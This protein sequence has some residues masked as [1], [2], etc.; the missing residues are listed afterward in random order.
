MALL[1]QAAHQ[2][3]ADVWKVEAFS[4]PPAFWSVLVQIVSL[5]VL[6]S[7]VLQPPTVLH[8]L[9]HPTNASKSRNYKPYFPSVFSS[10]MRGEGP[11][12][13]TWLRAENTA[14]GCVF[15]LPSEP[16]NLG[17]SEVRTGGK[18]QCHIGS[19]RA[20]AFHWKG[21]KVKQLIRMLGN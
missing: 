5:F 12:R 9:S 10:S 16:G 20:L 8:T 11:A 13:E 21:K 3:D 14:R 18:E 4:I 2:I 7:S 1:I 17:T 6:A 15:V 19:H